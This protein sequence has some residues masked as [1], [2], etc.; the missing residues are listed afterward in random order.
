MA[1][2]FLDA[3]IYIDFM[4]NRDRLLV[5]ELDGTDLFVSTLS[6]EIWMYVFK[7]IVPN[8]SLLEIFNIFNFVD[9]SSSIARKS[10]LGPTPDFE[11]NVQLHSA[12]EANCDT[13]ITKDLKLLKLGY[14]GKVHISNSL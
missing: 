2:V 7:R 11:D 12:S 13:F 9:Y 1:K 10:V 8:S 6:I 4:E 5:K 14:F 3:N